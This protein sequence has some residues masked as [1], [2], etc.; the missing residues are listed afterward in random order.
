MTRALGFVLALWM[1]PASA[2]TTDGA[3]AV[4][5]LRLVVARAGDSPDAIEPLLE[6]ARFLGDHAAL[7][8]AVVLAQDLPETADGWL[9]RARVSTTVHRFDQ[10][11]RELDAA[12]QAGADA[13]RVRRLR[14]VALAASDRAREAA[15]LL[16]RTCREDASGLATR[17]T[18]LASLGQ[19]EAADRAFAAALD[20]LDT[21]SPFPAAWLHFARGVLWAERAGDPGRGEQHYRRAVAVL[22]QF[23]LAQ[24]HLA[25]LE[26]ARGAVSPALDRWSAVAA[27]A[28]DPEVD[29]LLATIL[30]RCGDEAAARARFDAVRSHYARLE[31][32]LPGA[33]AHHRDAVERA[34]HPEPPPSMDVPPP[35]GCERLR[36]RGPIPA[37]GAPGIDA[38]R[39]PRPA[40]RMP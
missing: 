6:Q 7:R 34:L 14:S 22:P 16:D 13:C 23:V 30:R 38:A 40:V 39:R 20:A 2:A 37:R 10:A 15:A 27:P 1:G 12:A 26:V 21:T 25:E 4:S 33:F 29:R 17:A 19:H 18:V 3:I 24:V 31:R 36:A 11:Q 9:L 5:N 32:D 35:A 28:V 8:R